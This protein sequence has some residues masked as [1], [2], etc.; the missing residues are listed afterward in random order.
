M[1]ST[2]IHTIMVWAGLGILFFALTTLAVVDVLRKDF[3]STRNK[4]LWGL[5]A[6]FPFLGWLIY[7]LLGFRRGKVVHFQD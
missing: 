2:L 7:F 6:I 1:D 3:G 5:I 4:V